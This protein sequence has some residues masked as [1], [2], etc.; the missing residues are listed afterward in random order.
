M[1]TTILETGVYRGKCAE[2]CG[3]SHGFMPIVIEGV[4]LKDYVSWVGS[5]LDEE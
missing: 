3:R 2:L 4:T 1:S 5:Q